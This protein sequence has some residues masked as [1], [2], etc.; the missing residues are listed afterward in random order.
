MAGIG[1]LSP[2]GSRIELRGNLLDEVAVVIAE[3]RGE[4][5]RKLGYFQGKEGV[6]FVEVQCCRSSVR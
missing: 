2:V 4:G 3:G 1:I 5:G 6:N